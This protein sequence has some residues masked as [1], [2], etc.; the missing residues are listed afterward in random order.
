MRAVQAETR[1]RQVAG[2][3]RDAV[4]V[5]ARPIPEQVREH[6]V[7]PLARRL[8]AA[9]ADDREHGP[10]GPLQVPGEQLHPDEPGR[11]GEQHGTV[12]PRHSPRLQRQ[13]PERPGQARARLIGRDQLVDVAAGGR[14]PRAQVRLGVALGEVVAGGVGIVGRLELAAVDDPDRGPRRHHADL[15]VRPREHVVGAQVLGVHRDVGAAERLA[16]DQRHPGHVGRRERVHELRAEPDHAAATPAWCPACSRGCR[17]A[18]PAGCR[19][20]CT[21]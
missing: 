20:R 1:R 16:Q 4:G 13:R 3:R 21:C 19:T 14:H 7:D 17:R 18:R 8:V 11:A 9:G 6:G 12:G 15:G 10:L 2:D 5:P